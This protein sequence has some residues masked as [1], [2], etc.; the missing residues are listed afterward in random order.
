MPTVS[1]TTD[2]L[3]TTDAPWNL[4][5]AHYETLATRRGGVSADVAVFDLRQVRRPISLPRP[6]HVCFVCFC[7]GGTSSVL[8]SVVFSLWGVVTP[9]Q[10]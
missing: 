8:M 4:L 1:G 3:Q 7:F 9:P 6:R 10:W 2:G 5:P